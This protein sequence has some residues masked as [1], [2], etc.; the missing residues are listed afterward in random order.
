MRPTPAGR[1]IL[2]ALVLLGAIAAALY[3]AWAA[4]TGVSVREERWIAWIDYDNQPAKDVY[5]KFARV[6][7][8]R[9][10]LRKKPYNVTFIGADLPHLDK[11]RMSIEEALRHSPAAIVATSDGVAKMVRTVSP[12]IPMY[13]II[14]SDPVRE[15]LVPSLRAPGDNATG[16]TF[17]LP[18]DSKTVELIKQA[19]PRVRTVGLVSDEYWLEGA[20]MSSNFF[21]DCETLGI[22]LAP[23][24]A[25]SV[26]ELDEELRNARTAEVDAWYV[27]YS[28]LAFNAGPAIVERLRLTQKPTVYARSKFVTMGGMVSVQPVDASAMTVW[29]DTLIEMLDGVPAGEVPIMRPKQIEV[30]VNRGAIGSLDAATRRRILGVADRIY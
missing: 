17:F 16:Y 5:A 24:K 13:F 1:I 29:A 10:L 12:S 27:P 22:E 26:E 18:L 19:F 14:Q 28:P 25:G 20:N 21:A 7:S 23:Y 9:A 2:V 6:F 3:F 8:Q 11:L 4:R 15:G 30:T